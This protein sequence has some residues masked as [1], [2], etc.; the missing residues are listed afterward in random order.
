MSED[1]T[2]FR[3]RDR[4]LTFAFI[5]GPSTALAHLTVMYTL[6]PSACAS[7]SMTMLHVATA[8][9]LVIAAIAAA[10]GWSIHRKFRDSSEVLW[11]ERT[12]WLSMVTFVLAISSML[13]I[14]A[15]EI[16][17]WILRSCD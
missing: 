13:V 1:K 2:E 4:W 10:I 12:R 15:L 11:Q 7:G 3:T 8:V 16:P 14:V 6:V 17:N 9:S 5:L